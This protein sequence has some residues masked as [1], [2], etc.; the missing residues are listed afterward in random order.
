MGFQG[1]IQIYVVEIERTEVLVGFEGV[2]KRQSIIIR[3]CASDVALDEV[4]PVVV[5]IVSS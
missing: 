1:H 3:E 5:H 4:M 2:L